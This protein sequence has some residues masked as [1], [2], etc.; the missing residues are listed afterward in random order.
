MTKNIDNI[1]D[2]ITILGDNFPIIGISKSWLNDLNDPL[3]RIPGYISEGTCRK[4]KRGGGVVLYV[5]EHLTYKVRNEITTN[6]SEFESC[7]IEV[8]NLNMRNIVGI[9]YRPP[10]A[11]Y[12]QSIET[13][14]ETLEV[15][16]NENKQLYHVRF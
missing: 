13:L 9:V 11:S 14:N 5:K 6:T 15:I 12:A 1:R 16:S 7:F 2:Y 4:N 10:D 3:I 8:E